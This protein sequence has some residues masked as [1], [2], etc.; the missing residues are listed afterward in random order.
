MQ[1]KGQI[2]DCQTLIEYF[3]GMS[4][5]AMGNLMPL[6][7]TGEEEEDY[8]FGTKA[9]SEFK[10]AKAHSATVGGEMSSSS[11]INLPPNT[12]STLRSL[13]ILPPSSPSDIPRVVENLK[14]RK[15]RLEE[16][17]EIQQNLFKPVDGADSELLGDDAGKPKSEELQETEVS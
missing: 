5:T 11:S 13:S 1:I 14:A 6:V 15:A 8:F 16:I 12:R 2:D 3:S 10:K 9:R 17:A 4:A 7:K